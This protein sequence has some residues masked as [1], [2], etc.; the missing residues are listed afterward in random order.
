MG[1]AEHPTPH[2]NTTTV[3]ADIL[4]LDLDNPGHGAGL[5]QLLDHYAHDPMGGGQGLTAAVKTTL[6]E[7]LREIPHFYAALAF[8]DDR[9]VGLIDGFF[10]FSTFA[11]EPLLNIHDLVVH[12]DYRGR[13]IGRALLAHVEAVATET[14]CCKLTLEVLSHNAAALATYERAGFRPYQLDPQAGQA[15]FLQK[16]L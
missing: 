8:A 10:G 12:A 4:P 13:G 1:A 15:L 7:R 2:G 11:A 6:V 5:L 9:A 16:K 3:S 14:G